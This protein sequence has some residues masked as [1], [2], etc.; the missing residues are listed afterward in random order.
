MVA[1]V[2]ANNNRFRNLPPSSFPCLHCPVF[3]EFSS[4]QPQLAR[5]GR[6][7]SPHGLPQALFRYLAFCH[8]CL[9]PMYAS[10][11]PPGI[12]PPVG[13]LCMER[14]SH[15]RNTPAGLIFGRKLF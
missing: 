13:S 8:N 3:I 1:P 15:S 9:V 4:A 11:G 2:N 14:R 7:K 6:L 12:A 5:T 10:D